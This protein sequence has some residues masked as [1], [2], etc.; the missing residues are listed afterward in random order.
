MMMMAFVVHGIDVVV[1]YDNVALV[2]VAA[3]VFVVV[4]V[5]DDG[6]DNSR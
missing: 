5:D 1:N 4:A 6:G 3:D 2:V